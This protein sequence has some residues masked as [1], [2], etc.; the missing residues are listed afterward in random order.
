LDETPMRDSLTGLYNRRYMEAT[1][2][3]EVARAQRGHTALTVVMADIDSFEHIN[4][5]FGPAAGDAVLR[6]VGKT[7][8]WLMRIDDVS[9]RYGGAKFTLVL[10]EAR[11][12]AV[13]PRIEQLIASLIAIR[14]T[15]GGQVVDNVSMS[16]GIADFPSHADTATALLE[17]AETA[18]LE[19][20]RRG[21]NCA[22]VSQTSAHGTEEGEVAR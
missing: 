3:R 20:K 2:E 4:E 13:A 10:P 11:S 12:D 6:E 14:V 19:A 16:A 5:A 1:L 18:L 7:L 9:C 8:R 21:P 15:V 17:A 22:V